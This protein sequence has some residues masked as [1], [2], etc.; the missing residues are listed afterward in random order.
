MPVHLA[1]LL[2]V[3]QSIF[4]KTALTMPPRAPILQYFNKTPARSDKSLLDREIPDDVIYD[5]AGRMKLI[6]RDGVTDEYKVYNVNRDNRGVPIVKDPV[7]GHDYVVKHSRITKGVKIY[8]KILDTT[9]EPVVYD[10]ANMTM[11][12]IKINNH[13]EVELVPIE[14]EDLDSKFDD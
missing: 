3:M 12:Q 4:M 5:L 11:N 7:T 8:R 9:G 6:T 1:I 10:W 2:L 14:S 13:G